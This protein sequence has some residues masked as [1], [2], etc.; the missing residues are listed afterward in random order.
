MK[1]PILWELPDDIKERF[2]ERGA[3]KQRAMVADGHP[4]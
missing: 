1:L 3:G 4:R 2:G